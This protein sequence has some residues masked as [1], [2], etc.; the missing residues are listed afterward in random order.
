[1]I[2]ITQEDI[3]KG[4]IPIDSQFARE[5]GFTSDKFNGFLWKEDNVIYLSLIESH[6]EGK[7]NVR[8]LILTLQEKGYDIQ[9]LP[10]NARMVKICKSMQFSQEGEIWV[11]RQKNNSED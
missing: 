4:C 9:V 5:I 8:N 3:D 2:E 1:M 6:N 10:V 11:Y 7:G